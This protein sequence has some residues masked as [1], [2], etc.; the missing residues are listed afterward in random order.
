MTSVQPVPVAGGPPLALRTA[1]VEDGA[2]I[3]RLVRDTGALDLNSPYAYLLA[4]RHHGHTSLVAEGEDGLA[5][6]VL[7]YRPPR[8][9]DT[10]FVWQIAVA[11]GARGRGL[12]GSLLLSLVRRQAEG[13][14]RHLEATIT[15]DNQASWAIFRGLAEELEVPFTSEPG[16]P[17]ELFP[18]TRGGEPAHPREDLIRVG[19]FAYGSV[20]AA[21]REG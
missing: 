14:A 7:S 13:G 1:T 8:Q 17:A 3:W 2:G 4:C 6:F 15:P 5:G 18:D 16:F 9:P 19:P 10:I 12:G 20:P 11:R 21:P